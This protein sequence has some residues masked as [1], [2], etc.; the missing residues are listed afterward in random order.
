MRIT[1]FD[2]LLALLKAENVPF[3]GNRDTQVVEI[4][5][6]SGPLSTE[7]VIRWEI[8]LVLAQFIVAFPYRVPPVRFQKI[9]HTISLLN[10]RL[11]WPGWCLDPNNQLLYYRLVVPR[12]DDGGMDVD[13]IQ[14]LSETAIDTV[15]DFLDMLVQI[16][17]DDKDPEPLLEVLTPKLTLPRTAADR[18]KVSDTPRP[19]DKSAVDA[20]VPMPS[21]LSEALPTQTAAPSVPGS[22]SK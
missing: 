7:M 9:E 16:V 1:T 4:G 12:G 3:R 8:R 11:I 21:G 6:N 20:P 18:G 17:R 10:H 5:V 19:D 2:E 13:H 15:I 14:R 22:D